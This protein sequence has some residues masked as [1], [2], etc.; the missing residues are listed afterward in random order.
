M[1]VSDSDLQECLEI[2]EYV[3]TRSVKFQVRDIPCAMGSS[4]SSNC[5][6][7]GGS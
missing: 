7:A 2:L 5:F 6:L 1:L 3:G 4:G